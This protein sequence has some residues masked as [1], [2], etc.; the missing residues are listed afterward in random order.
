MENFP[1]GL[2]TGTSYHKGIANLEIRTK[3]DEKILWPLEEGKELNII[4]RTPRQC[5]GYRSLVGKS[6]LVAC[7][8]NVKNIGSSQCPD[9]L[10]EA[11]ILP[12]LRC[13]GD[14]CR[15]PWKRDSCIQVDNHALYLAS[16]APGVVKVGVSRWERRSQR[17]L[18][19]GAR[20]ALIV[21]QDD[22]QMI[23]RYETQIK[24]LGYRDRLSSVHKMQY[25]GQGASAEEKN[26]FKELYSSLD[27]IKKRMRAPW[28]DKA[29]EVILPE[30]KKF[31]GLEY[32]ALWK[33]SL[34]IGPATFSGKISAVHGS[35]LF[36]T[37]EERTTPLII[38]LKDLVGYYLEENLTDSKTSGQMTLELLA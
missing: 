36:L 26:L 13:D 1:E 12:C 25:I 23:R 5:I 7:P 9:C 11:H 10:E 28:L 14:V 24:K 15:N 16:F 21:A 38:D 18:E 32:S 3:E 4:L 33:P 35:L 34:K 20:V 27:E 31:Q 22:G 30:Y 2:L 17:L 6:T 8:N 29:E 19:Q 37:N